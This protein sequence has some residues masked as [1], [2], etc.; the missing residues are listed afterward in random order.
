M[1]STGYIG[2]KYGYGSYQ[3]I[4]NEIPPHNIFICAFAGSCAVT[5]HKTP[6]PVENIVF[7]IS[8]IVIK[9]FWAGE[10]K[11]VYDF[12]NEDFIKWFALTFRAVRED[13]FIYMDPPYKID[14]RSNGRLYYK[15]ELTD[16]DHVQLLQLCLSIKCKVAISAYRCELYD[17]ML[18]NW[19]VK[20]WKVNTHN[21]IK[22]EA[23]YM[24]YDKPKF[25]HQYNFLGEDRTDRQRIKRRKIK[26]AER[27]E[28]MNDNERYC[29]I[30]YIQEYLNN[31]L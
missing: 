31:A 19:R 3:K 9:K 2:N 22:Y 24:N 13:V 17:S 20:E 25:L 18:K 4:I 21:G 27:F 5:K 29:I 8:E 28:A 23:L 6:A 30:N 26:F 10:D 11:N 14:S 12:R 15:N 16:S 7:E 1:K